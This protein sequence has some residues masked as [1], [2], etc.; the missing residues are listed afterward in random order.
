MACLA[1]KGCVAGERT[2]RRHRQSSATK[3]I[4]SCNLALESANVH[5]RSRASICTLTALVAFPADVVGFS[6]KNCQ[7]QLRT[8]QPSSLSKGILP[9]LG[10]RTVQTPTAD[11]HVQSAQVVVP[12]PDPPFG[13]TVDLITLPVPS[14]QPACNQHP[15]SSAMVCSA[16]VSSLRDSS[17]FLAL[18]KPDDGAIPIA[19]P[20]APEP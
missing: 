18:T 11:S 3:S 17:S 15:T 12:K 7:A 16:F 4:E 8:K 19:I 14:S 6:A 9:A 13:T 5:L 20:T 1:C 10:F 2:G